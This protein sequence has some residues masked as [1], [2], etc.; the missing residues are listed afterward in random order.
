MEWIDCKLGQSE[1]QDVR[2][3]LEAIDVGVMPVQT[4]TGIATV[5]SH[6]INEIGASRG[7]YL[8]RMLASFLGDRGMDA[9]QVERLRTRMETR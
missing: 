5:T 8:D 6:A 4:L 2:K 9:A 3:L 7:L 1:F